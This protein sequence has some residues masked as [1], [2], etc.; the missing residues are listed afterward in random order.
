MEAGDDSH[1]RSQEASDRAG[2]GEPESAGSSPVQARLHASLAV[3]FAVA[4]VGVL[5]LVVRVWLGFHEGDPQS[6]PGVVIAGMIGTLLLPVFVGFA[7][8][9]L[10]LSWRCGLTSAYLRRGVKPSFCRSTNVMLCMVLMLA[11]SAVCLKLL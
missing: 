4:G 10:F 6:G 11:A 7:A 3:L 9:F 2:S 8:G 5:S 1:V